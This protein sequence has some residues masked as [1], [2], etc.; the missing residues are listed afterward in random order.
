MNGQQEDLQS[1]TGNDW[2]HNMIGYG[3][4]FEHHPHEWPQAIRGNGPLCVCNCCRSQNCD[5]QNPRDPRDPP[6]DRPPFSDLTE[7]DPVEHPLSVDH[8]IPFVAPAMP[9]SGPAPPKK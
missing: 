7:N 1:D 5:E 2:P 3:P 8:P 4:P 9:A 6:S